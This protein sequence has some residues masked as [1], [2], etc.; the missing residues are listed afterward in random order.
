[1]IDEFIQFHAVAAPTHE[2]QAS[3]DLLAA[4]KMQSI[5]AVATK[6]ALE[7]ETEELKQE[8]SNWQLI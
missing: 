5:P 3:D 4:A 1:M 7:Q 6:R 2:S 8:V